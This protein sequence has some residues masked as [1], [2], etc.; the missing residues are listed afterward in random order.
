MSK[1]IMV[2]GAGPG[3]GQAVGARFGREGWTVILAS[4]SSDRLTGLVAQLVSEGITAYGVVTD[5]ATLWRCA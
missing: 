3:I 1:S 5:A 4:R 2:V